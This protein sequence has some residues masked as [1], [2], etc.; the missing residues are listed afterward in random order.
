MSNRTDVIIMLDRIKELFNDLLKILITEGDNSVNYA[1][2]ELSLNLNRIEHTLSN[3][4]SEDIDVNQV[5]KEVERS[6]KSMYPPRD[7]LTE[8]FVWRNDFDERVKANESLD[9]IKEELRQMLNI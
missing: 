5:L 1:K 3:V 7:G 6:Y 9:R 4:H 2:N 8:F